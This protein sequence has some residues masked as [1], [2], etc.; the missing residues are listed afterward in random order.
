MMY[1]HFCSELAALAAR[2]VVGAG[3]VEGVEIGPVQNAQHFAKLKMLLAECRSD[4]AIIAGGEPLD[5]PG[6][7]IPPT[8]VHDVG[9][10][11][12]IVREEQFGPILPVLPYD[13]ID[14]VITRVNASEYGLAGSVW[15]RDR[16]RAM[17]VAARLS[18]GTVWVN[19][20]LVVDPAIPFRGAKQSGIGTE[21]GQEGL[22]EYTQ[23]MIVNAAPAAQE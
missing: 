4:G 5:R 15:G 10:E 3:T 6:Y 13:D 18:S 14:E 17:G 7:F 12:R 19:Q 16:D 2:T 8:I 22:W 9:D 11:A 20:H 23:A 21:L 1:D